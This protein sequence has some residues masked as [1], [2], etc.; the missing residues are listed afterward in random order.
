MLLQNETKLKLN[1][2]DFI[3]KKKEAK[4]VNAP[5]PYPYINKTPLKLKP[6]K[7]QRKEL[8][9]FFEKSEIDKMSDKAVSEFTIFR[10]EFTATDKGQILIK[11]DGKTES[12]DVGVDLANAFKTMD[13]QRCNVATLCWCSCKNIKSWCNINTRFCCT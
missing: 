5:D 8:E 11:R 12:W 6:I 9:R 7:I 1:F 13:Q 10:Q 3:A 4:A 2:I